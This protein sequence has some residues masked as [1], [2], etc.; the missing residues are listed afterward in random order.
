MFDSILTKV[1]FNLVIRRNLSNIDP[2][3]RSILSLITHSSD[4]SI[5][6]FFFL[7]KREMI[8]YLKTW[9]EHR[10][11]R[12]RLIKTQMRKIKQ[13]TL[14][15]IF[16]NFGWGSKMKSTPK[17]WFY[18][19]ESFLKYLMKKMQGEKKLILKWYTSF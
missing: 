9:I 5:V 19:I 17:S 13:K 16:K 14:I 15:F 12:Q 8:E 3:Q 6:D 18:T 7:E 4:I 10:K 11:K 1:H 2:L